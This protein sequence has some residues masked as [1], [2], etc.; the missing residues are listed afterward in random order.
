MAQLSVFDW[1][2]VVYISA[3]DRASLAAR[4]RIISKFQPEDSKN[5]SR[6]LIEY[7]MAYF[8]ALTRT[9]DDPHSE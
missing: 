5:V 7:Q 1:F 4:H 2:V 3:L 9:G 6:A 8:Q